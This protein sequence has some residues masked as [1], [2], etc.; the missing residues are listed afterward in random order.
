MKIL[1]I[2]MDTCIYGLNSLSA[3]CYV[4]EEMAKEHEVIL[5]TYSLP[6]FEQSEKPDNLTIEVMKE[7]T[8][9][10]IEKLSGYDYDLVYCTSI[11]AISKALQLSRIKNAKCIVQI[12]DCPTFR[13]QPIR[14]YEQWGREWESWVKLLPQVDKI[15]CNHPTTAEIMNELAGHYGV[16]YGDKLVVVPYGI[17]TKEADKCPPQEKLNQV[18]FVSNLRFFKGLDIIIYALAQMKDK[19]M[20]KVI[21]VGDGTEQFISNRGGQIQTRYINLAFMAGV[22]THFCGGVNDDEKYYIIKQSKLALLPLITDTIPSIFPLEAV[23]SGTPAIVSDT[24]ILREA[25]G[26]MVTYVNRFDTRAWSD[27]I[28]EMMDNPS[29]VTKE[30]KD[31]IL[32]Q[33]SCFSHANGLIK[34]FEEC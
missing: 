27:K 21:G 1:Y 14:G 6:P 9:E 13:L 29:T 34:V 18:V 12:L 25:C 26:D 17:A 15:V 28:K 8:Y 24:M 7:F 23:Y 31:F 22:P 19:P 30:M 32:N 11:P 3:E 10:S 33:R 2:S 16:Y 20:L 4:A 5:V